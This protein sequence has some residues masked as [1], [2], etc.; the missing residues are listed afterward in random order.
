[1]KK[2]LLVAFLVSASS[3]SAGGIVTPPPSSGDPSLFLGLTWTFAGSGSA[4][5]TAGVSLKVLST[6]ER[7]APALAAGVTY[8]F[9]GSFGCDV[10][11]AYNSSVT[12]TLGYDFCQRGLQMGLGGT[13]KPA[14]GG[15][16]P[17]SVESASF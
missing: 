4:G 11:L 10:G 14:A 8:N 7:D 15:P 6:N 1:M 9:N 12:L 5:G 17:G 13:K 16:G 2:L 3:A